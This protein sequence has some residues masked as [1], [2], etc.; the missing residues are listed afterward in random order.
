[1]KN[2]LSRFFKIVSVLLD[3]PGEDYLS[4]IEEI[5]VITAGMPP[6]KFKNSINEFIAYIKSQPLARIREIYTDVFDV[7]PA[8][9]LNLT[10]HIQGD[11]EKRAGLLARLQQVY[12]DAGYERIS[13]ELPDYLPLLLEFL[14]VCAEDTDVNLIWECFQHFDT[15]VDRLRQTS[16]EYAFLLQPLTR[17]FSTFSTIKDYK[18]GNHESEK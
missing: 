11:T 1:M 14:S 13:G 2:N 7:S 4:H 8:T 6:D 9:T 17:Q 12:Q 5:E 18:G 10:Y 16:A 3:Y 15:Y